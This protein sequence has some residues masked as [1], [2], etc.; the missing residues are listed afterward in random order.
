MPDGI[1]V[2]ID[3]EKVKRLLDGLEQRGR[4]MK[5]AFSA[6]GDIIATSVDRNFEQGGRYSSPDSWRGGSNRWQPL[7]AATMFNVGGGRRGY[8]KSGKRLRKSGARR[9]GGKRILI[10][11][12]NLA[13]SITKSATNDSVT[14][15]TDSLYAAIHQYGGMAGRARKVEIPARPFLLVQ[16]EDLAE[17]RGTIMDH[18]VGA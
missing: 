8:I 4:N 17:I 12:G 16:D 3:D 14:V 15:G 13:S 5:P 10:D 2:K 11:S 7:S 9:I 6:I 1:S 18:L